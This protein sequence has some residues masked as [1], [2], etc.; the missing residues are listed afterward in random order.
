MKKIFAF[1]IVFIFVSCSVFA[2]KAWEFE[3]KVYGGLTYVEH[4]YMGNRDKYHDYSVGCGMEITRC[5]GNWIGIEVS[6][7]TNWVLGTSSSMQPES[8]ALSISKIPSMSLSTGL[9][10]MIPVSEIIKVKGTFGYGFYS[11]TK[12]HYDSVGNYFTDISTFTGYMG[13]LGVTFLPVKHFGFSIG[14]GYCMSYNKVDE[15]FSSGFR[16]EGTVISVYLTPY[17]SAVIRLGKK[18]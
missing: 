9:V 4:D 1:F 14:S 13:S 11:Y 3:P 5:W 16:Y 7:D 6:V 18:L 8:A 17:V 12:Y 15:I 10:L 2:V